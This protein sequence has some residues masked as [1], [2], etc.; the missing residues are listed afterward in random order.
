[1]GPLATGATTRF[2]GVDGY[3]IGRGDIRVGDSVEAVQE[4]IGDEWVTTKVRIVRLIPRTT[5]GGR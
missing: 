5:S 1:L 4:K 2:Y 3:P